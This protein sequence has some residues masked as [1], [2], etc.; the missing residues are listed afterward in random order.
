[1]NRVDIIDIFN[2][3][4]EAKASDIHIVVGKPP[5]IR[6]FGKIK[7]LPDFPILSA[8][9][10]KA[11]IYG[12]L[13]KDQIGRFEERLELDFSY[14]VPGLSRFR[15]NV[16]S[17]KNGIEA[18]MRLIPSK[19]PSARELRLTDAIVALTRLPRGLVLVTGPTGSGKSTTIASLIDIINSE[20][21]ENIVTIEDPIEFIYE[22]KNCVVRQRE[23]GLN[24]HS[25][26][27]ALRHVLRQD[28]DIILI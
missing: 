5:M 3:A 20:R 22:S 10:T 4:F 24:T 14:N 12:M 13:Y 11:L 26:N 19:I 23:V 25:F 9:N 16:M 7:P 27:D 8:E 17:Q 1:M 21:Y 18:V 6:F 15:C 28:P 2:A